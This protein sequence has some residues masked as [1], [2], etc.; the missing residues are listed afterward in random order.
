MSRW[1]KYA[2]LAVVLTA[3]LSVGAH[4]A[5]SLTAGRADA[6]NCGSATLT[7]STLDPDY[8]PNVIVARE[9]LSAELRA[10]FDRARA[11]EDSTDVD[12]DALAGSPFLQRIG[13]ATI[14]SST[15]VRADGTRYNAIAETSN[16]PAIAG[17]PP[18]T[19]AVVYP[20][21]AIY[22]V[23]SPLYLPAGALLGIVVAYRRVDAWLRF[24]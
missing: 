18:L 4:E 17:T 11:G 3:L 19:N 8:D 20:L 5:Q 14:A 13:D 10:A 2:V 12:P 9:N 22:R 24:D 23:F 21:L 6:T 7:V 15:V 16:C 1:P